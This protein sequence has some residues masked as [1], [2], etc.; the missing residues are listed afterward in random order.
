[1]CF[2]KLYSGLFIS[3]FFYYYY[4]TLLCNGTHLQI[5]LINL[6]HNCIFFFISYISVM[7]YYISFQKDK[8]NW[9]RF[10]Q[11]LS[12]FVLIRYVGS[13][14]ESAHRLRSWKKKIKSANKGYLRFLYRRKWQQD[15]ISKSFLESNR[16][17][18]Y[19]R[20]WK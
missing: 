2:F 10:I 6:Y 14:L 9:M 5:Y 18:T 20:I 17:Q 1:M 4:Y 16:F 8:E 12:L 15:I 7:Y 13:L 11:N 19:N 3:T